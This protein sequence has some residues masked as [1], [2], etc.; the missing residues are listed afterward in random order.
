MIIK[1]TLHRGTPVYLNQPPRRGGKPDPEKRGGR[2]NS[3]ALDT[4]PRNL[5]EKKGRRRRGG[6]TYKLFFKLL[7]VGGNETEKRKEK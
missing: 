7:D 3:S 1:L 4:I 2:E 6:K 5:Q